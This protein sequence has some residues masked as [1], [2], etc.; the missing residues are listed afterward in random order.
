MRHYPD[1]LR[2]FC[3][4]SREDKLPRERHAN[5]D[6]A[7]VPLNSDNIFARVVRIEL[8]VVNNTG[9]SVVDVPNLIALLRCLSAYVRHTMFPS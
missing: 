9:A 8:N 5:A 6:T 4:R 7:V 1:R 3:G 2:P